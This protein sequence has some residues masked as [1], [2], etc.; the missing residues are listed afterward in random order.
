MKKVVMT[1]SLAATIIFSIMLF[2]T[3]TAFAEIPQISDVTSL[4]YYV[5]P[6]DE[7]IIEGQSQSVDILTDKNADSISIY[8][9][10]ELVLQSSNQY[11]DIEYGRLWTVE[12]GFAQSGEQ[13]LTAY[14]SNEYGMTGFNSCTVNVKKEGSNYEDM[15]IISPNEGDSMLYSHDSTRQITFKFDMNDDTLSDT[16]KIA[17]TVK[18]KDSGEII[19]DELT[20]DFNSEDKSASVNFSKFFPWLKFNYPL[21]PE[22]I[23]I[24]KN[25]K[26][27]EISASALDYNGVVISNCAE[28]VSFEISYPKFN[29]GT[30]EFS[31]DGF[32]MNKYH[33]DCYTACSTHS[34]LLKW[35]GYNDNNTK[36]IVN[37]TADGVTLVNKKQVSSNSFD[38]SDYYITTDPDVE[39]VLTVGVFSDNLPYVG[40]LDNSQPNVFE[41]KFV[42]EEHPS[43]P[44]ISKVAVKYDAL[45]CNI[46][47]CDNIYQAQ[48]ILK[49]S[50]KKVIYEDYQGE[51]LPVGSYYVCAYIDRFNCSDVS[52]DVSFKVTQDDVGLYKIVSDAVN[53]IIAEEGGYT[54]VVKKDVNAL[55]I[56]KICWHGVNAHLL[57]CNIM[58]ANP[59]E[60]KANLEGS[61]IYE[62]LL[63][64]SNTW[65]TRTVNDTEKAILQKALATDNSKMVQDAMADDFI[66]DY[67]SYGI[68]KG[69]EDG[70]MLIYFAD[71]CNQGGKG[72][73]NKV[74]Q[75]LDEFTLD[76]LHKAALA[77][78]TYGPY[79]SRR[80]RV[81]EAITK[82]YGYDK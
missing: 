61:T 33:T 32:G 43:T 5:A 25:G 47:G 64:D 26:R 59:A 53:I 62:E 6:Q 35:T 81:Y 79:A 14:A 74:L 29:A 82:T 49:D 34:T 78:S 23:D 39:Y 7:S 11:T 8:V 13:T 48:L 50:N 1:L 46:S 76:A 45:T 72:G 70:G 56:G 52:A 24:L 42:C 17:I 19:I 66:Y 30:K 10:E 63:Q 2:G 31:L 9:G 80:N 27:F 12:I 71:L 44:V 77:S 20:C 3:L 58:D 60:L 22:D 4:V 75:T 65:S 38:L 57:L 67:I 37:L 16:E 21:D 36:Y 40:V 51:K 55:S 73:A 18:D 69:I 54:T 28:Q 41:A 15:H 68:S